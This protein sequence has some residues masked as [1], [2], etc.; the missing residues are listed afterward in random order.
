MRN[1]I[2]LNIAFNIITHLLTVRFSRCY[3]ISPPTQHM[4][5]ILNATQQWIIL[6]SL[7]LWTGMRRCAHLIQVKTVLFVQLKLIN[8]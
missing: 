5:T 2:N 3:R 6:M 4:S 8:L 1:V 7:S